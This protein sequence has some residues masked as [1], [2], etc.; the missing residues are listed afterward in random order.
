MLFIGVFIAIILHEVSHLLA[1]KITRAGE[2]KKFYIGKKGVG[3]VWEP[4]KFDKKKMIIITLSGSL[5]NLLSAGLFCAGGLTE[6]AAVSFWFGILNLLIP[7]KSA[8]G[9]RAYKYWKD[10]EACIE[11]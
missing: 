3:I 10:G 7:M 1:I 5:I 2:I 8:D 6:I 9:Y 11:K 4:F